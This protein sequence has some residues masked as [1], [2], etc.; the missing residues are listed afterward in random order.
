[1]HVFYKSVKNMFFYFFNLQI[2]VFNV[3]ALYQFWCKSIKKFDSGSANTD[4]LTD[5]NWFYNLFRSH[6]AGK[7]CT[8]TAR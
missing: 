3:Y 2:N 6:G 5:I 8:M 1:M 7:N 4:T